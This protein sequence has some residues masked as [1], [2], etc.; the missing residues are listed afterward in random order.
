MGRLIKYL[1]FLLVLG[2]AALAV[3]AAIADLPA[4]REP[5]S[6]AAPDPTG[7]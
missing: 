2:A 1:F 4:P 3:Y 7:S 6:I 5:I